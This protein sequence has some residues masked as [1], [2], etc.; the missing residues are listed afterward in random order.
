LIAAA[1]IPYYFGNR[2]EMAEVIHEAETEEAA[3]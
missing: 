3:D 1:G 2:R